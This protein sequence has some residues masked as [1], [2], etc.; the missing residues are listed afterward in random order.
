MR[1]LPAG[2]LLVL[3]G[4]IG[5]AYAPSLRH[6]P[7]S[8]HWCY[9]LVTVNHDD[10]ASLVAHTWSYSRTRTLSP[11]DAALFRPLL[12]VLMAAEK[13]VFANH[14]RAWQAAGVVL[15]AVA[16]GL[17]FLIFRRIRTMS[18]GPET[19]RSAVDWLPY[20]LT[21]FFALNFAIVEQI[22]F[23]HITGYMLFSVLMLA[24]LRLL[25]EFVR[26][27]KLPSRHEVWLLAGVLAPRCG[28]IVYIRTWSVL[29]CVCRAVPGRGLSPSR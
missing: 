13:A 17:L 16:C 15:H 11:G 9:L 2:F 27:S 6:A 1:L 8:D 18:T 22:V 14:F 21:L 10:F 4:L 20:A 3:A 28:G 29:R 26:E 25:L 19:P 7:R 5:Y 12:F 24:A 23:S